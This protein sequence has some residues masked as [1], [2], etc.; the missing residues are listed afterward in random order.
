MKTPLVSCIVLTH[1]SAAY[2][3]KCLE[4]LKNISYPSV[5]I[6]VV[7]NN[8]TDSTLKILSKFSN[9]VT[10][11]SRDVNDGYAGGHSF[12]IKKAKGYYLFLLNPDTIVTKNFLQPL[13]RKLQRNK[14]IAACQPIVYLMSSKK[15]INLTGKVTH[16]LGLDWLRD[17]QEVKARKSGEIISISGSGILLRKS[18]LDQVGGFDHEYFMYYEDSD[19]SWRLRITGYSLWYCAESIIFHDYKF[20][21]DEKYQ[22]LNQ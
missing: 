9:S 6:L 19:L 20:I 10:I 22:S 7:D 17:Y 5:E 16:F 14:M 18:A 3:K 21:P 15:I 11:F 8:S 12:G 2:I 1:N 4:A 13:V